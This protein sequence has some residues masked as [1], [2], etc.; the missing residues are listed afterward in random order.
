MNAKKWFFITITSLET[1]FLLS[2]ISMGAPQRTAMDYAESVN[3]YFDPQTRVENLCVIMPKNDAYIRTIDGLP[4]IDGVIAPGIHHLVVQY[5]YSTQRH[6]FSSDLISMVVPFENGKYYYLDYEITDG[7]TIFT[8]D[9][10]QFSITELT[11]PVLIQKAGNAIVSVKSGLEKQEPYLV[12][13]K[14][15]PARLEGTWEFNLFRITFNEG[16][17]LIGI[18]VFGQEN[19]RTSEGRYFFDNQTIVALVEK[20]TG[21]GAYGRLKKIWYYELKNGVLEINNLALKGEVCCSPVV[22]RLRV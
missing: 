19:A 10:I 12:F 7:A 8:A 15:N 6:N 17:Y 1:V 3:F 5:W 4:F 16:R 11:D 20:E 13:S 2:C 9:T 14:S 22:V 18:K 21:F